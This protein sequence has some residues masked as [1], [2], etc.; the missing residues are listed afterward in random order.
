M[1]V[2]ILTVL[3]LSTFLKKSKNL[4]MDPLLEQIFTEY[5]HI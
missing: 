3:A 1:I 2:H 4:L 5:K